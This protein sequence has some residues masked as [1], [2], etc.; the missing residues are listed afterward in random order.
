MPSRVADV[1]LEPA[2]HHLAQTRRVRLHAAGEP[3]RVQHLQ[4]RLPRLR[5]T[6]CAGS[7]TG[8]AGAGRARRP[9]ARPGSACCRTAIPACPG[10]G[11]RGAVVRLVDDQQVKITRIAGLRR[12][13]LVEQPLHPRRPQPLQADDHPRV[14]RERVGLQAVGAAQL[15]QRRRVQDREVQAELAR[16][17]PR[18][19]SA[20]ATPGRP[21]A[22][23]A[24]GG[25][26][27]SPGSTRPASIGLAQAHV[28]GD[29]QVHPRHRQRPRHRLQLVLLDRAPERN[30]ACSVRVSA[31]ATVPQRTASRNA[32]SRCGSSQPASVTS[33][34]WLAGTISR[35]G[36]TSQTSVSSS[37]RS[38][39]LTLVS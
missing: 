18:A 5:S 28:V 21:P 10:R 14:H 39:S 2:D 31:L 23:A 26:A 35:P 11:R 22:P 37:P 12:Q 36:S 24:P 15:P 16:P 4:Q 34:S 7:R 19:I 27:A 30:G 8:T 32:P 29:Q 6:R 20:S 38:S 13:H 33:G 9:G 1:V 25:A 3:L 17:S